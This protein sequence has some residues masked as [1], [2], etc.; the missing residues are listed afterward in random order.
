M[1]PASNMDWTN[2]LNIATVCVSFSFILAI[3]VGL[4]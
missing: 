1:N 2:R 3:V 4:I